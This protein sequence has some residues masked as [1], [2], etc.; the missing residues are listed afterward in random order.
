MAESAS[1]SM[2][3][4]T[5]AAD[6]GLANGKRAVSDAEEQPAKRVRKQGCQAGLSVMVLVSGPSGAVQD[7]ASMGYLRNLR[8]GL[9]PAGQC[10]TSLR[11]RR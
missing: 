7:N 8:R 2:A 5:Q 6:G 10:C 1:Q 11:Q 9:F 3:A 4:S